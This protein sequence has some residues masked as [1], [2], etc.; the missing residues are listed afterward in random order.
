MFL[1]NT[2]M[3]ITAQIGPPVNE[4]AYIHCRS[5]SHDWS[6]LEARFVGTKFT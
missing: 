4:E 1:K 6:T 3:L 2:Q 5:N